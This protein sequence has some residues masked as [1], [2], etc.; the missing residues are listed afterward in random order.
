MTR[1]IDRLTLGLLSPA[2][3]LPLLAAWE[4]LI[5]LGLLSARYLRAT[6]A[7]LFLQMPGTMLPLFFFPRETFIAFP[8]APTLEGQYIVKNLVLVAAAIVVGATVRGGQ[9]SSKPAP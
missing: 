9:L 2:V 4:T 6:L 8:H 1:A 7:L 3:S 5:G